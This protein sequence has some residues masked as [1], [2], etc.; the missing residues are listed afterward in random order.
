MAKSGFFESFMSGF[1]TEAGNDYDMRK[2]ADYEVDI[3]RRKGLDTLDLNDELEKRK[4]KRRA[5]QLKESM[6]LAFGSNV[7]NAAAQTAPAVLN[8]PAPT[9]PVDMTAPAGAQAE[10]E[11]LIDET[12]TPV[13]DASAEAV[14][15]RKP[16]I[17]TTNIAS[18][19]GGIFSHFTPEQRTK[20]YALAQSKNIDIIQ[21]A[22]EIEKEDRI[23]NAQSPQFK[24]D[25][26]AAETEAKIAASNIPDEE[27]QAM[28]LDLG[29]PEIKQATLRNSAQEKLYQ[30]F[31][32]NLWASKEAQEA[33]ANNQ[34]MINTANKFTALNL[35]N[36][37]GGPLLALPYAK[38]LATM[39][40]AE[41]QGMDDAAKVMTMKSIKA[42]GSGTAISDSDR[43]FAEKAGL[44]LA[45][46]DEANAAQAASMV[47]FATVDNE[48]R[49]F[50]QSVASVQG[51]TAQAKKMWKEYTNANPVFN[52]TDI[53]NIQINEDR[54]DWR[55]WFAN[56][57]QAPEGEEATEVEY[58]NAPAIGTT[59]DGYD[60]IGG[61]PASPESWEKAE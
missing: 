34:S 22:I 35:N 10:E 39:F 54:Q 13:V 48:Y 6:A 5:E 20:A 47:A 42:L 19:N 26:A 32:D 44:S 61:D 1:L 9:A 57:G 24:A 52:S 55:T 7:N 31:H 16:D 11:V 37:T 58:P 27:R 59:V 21:A 17:Q 25:V 28:L 45:K 3:A 60:Y 30:S 49:E 4:E 46:L 12:D 40:S 18:S 14:V 23:I 29:L 50:M 43:Q 15:L 56:G 38:D 33:I 41:Y 51:D 8:A 53:N 2:K 36:P